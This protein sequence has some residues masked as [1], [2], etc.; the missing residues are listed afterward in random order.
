MYNFTL[1]MVNIKIIIYIFLIV[2]VFHLIS[3]FFNIDIMEYI[4]KGK[5]IEYITE[6]DDNI[7]ELEQSLEQLKDISTD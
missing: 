4:D 3:Y 2:L 1:S 6:I 7:N 5:D